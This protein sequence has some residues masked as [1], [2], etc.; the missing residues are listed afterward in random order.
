MFVKSSSLKKISIDSYIHELFE[1]FQDIVV[2]LDFQGKIVYLSKV[3]LKKLGYKEEEVIGKNFFDLFIRKEIRKRLKIIFSSLISKKK[4]FQIYENDILKKNGSRLFVSWRNIYFKAAGAD[5]ILSIGVDKT[6]DNKTKEDLERK[7][8]KFK[9]TTDDWEQTFNSINDLVAILDKDLNVI[10]ANKKAAELSGKKFDPNKSIKCFNFFQGNKGICEGCVVRNVLRD[11]KPRD[12]LIDIFGNRKYHLWFYPILDEDGK[13]QQVIEYGKDVTLEERVKKENSVL[14]DAM[15][16]AIDPILIVSLNGSI[17]NWNKGA[18]KVFGYKANEIVGESFIRIIPEDKH[19]ETKRIFEKILKDKNHVYES[20]RLK[21][22]KTLIPILCSSFVLE[23]DKGNPSGVAS[24]MRDISDLKEKEVQLIKEKNHYEKSKQE[25]ELIFDSLSDYII[26]LDKDLHIINA[27][28]KAREDLKIKNFNSIKT[29]K[30]FEITQKLTDRCPGCQVKELIKTKKPINF[31]MKYGAR[32]FDVWQ[33]PVLDN[34][35]NI[36]NIIEYSRDVTEEQLFKE[37]NLFLANIIRDSLET[38][39]V[40]DFNMKILEWNHGAEELL[41]YKREEMI[42]KSVFTII[43]QSRVEE[44]KSC[45]N[46]IM[47]NEFHVFESERITKNK[48]RIPVSVFAYLIEDSSDKPIAVSTF[49]RDISDIKKQEHS[50]NEHL[51]ILE[52][53]NKE[54]NIL[55]KIVVSRE[56]KMIELKKEINKF[57]QGK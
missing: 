9:K 54:L 29:Q 28:K 37:K 35:G 50:L 8:E 31:S 55:E 14:V 13:I 16:K 27:N 12:I 34:A 21:K 39:I 23:D 52:Q 30:C 32:I 11:K 49:V 15:D 45:F 4:T 25:W 17:V 1:N 40:I 36:D 20:V 19:V 18:E 5:L 46:Q 24:F 56:L 47:A 51:E 33:Y 7:E 26:L 57:K 22:D 10:R 38:I 48:K 2:V 53:K 44:T 41:G 42:G 6:S 43:P 3:T